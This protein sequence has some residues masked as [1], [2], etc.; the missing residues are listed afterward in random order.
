MMA[1]YCDELQ[2]RVILNM[3]A[4]TGIAGHDGRLSVAYDCVCGQRGRLFTGRD[5]IAGGMSGHMSV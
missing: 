4:V 1:V 2:K 5:R 3:D